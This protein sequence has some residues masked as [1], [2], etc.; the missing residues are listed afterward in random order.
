MQ[1]D[2]PPNFLFSTASGAFGVV[3]FRDIV[4]S[5]TIDPEIASSALHK[6]SSVIHQFFISSSSGGKKGTKS[7]IWIAAG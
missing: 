7:G 3:P 4:Y 5:G 1:P 6:S 2:S